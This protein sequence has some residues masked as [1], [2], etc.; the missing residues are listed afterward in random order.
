MIFLTIFNY[1]KIYINNDDICLRYIVAAFEQIFVY[2]PR[3]RIFNLV[4][5]KFDVFK[6]MLYTLCT[7]LENSPL[8]SFIDNIFL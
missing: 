1:E 7:T 5:I 8:F 2:N 6:N 4:H 3:R